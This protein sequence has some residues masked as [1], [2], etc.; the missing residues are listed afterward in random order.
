MPITRID[1]AQP[2][3]LDQAQPIPGGGY[4]IPGYATRVGVLNYRQPNG[5]IRR[6][7]RPPEEAFAP[8]TLASYQGAPLTLTH[9]PS[10]LIRSPAEREKFSVGIVEGQGRQDGEFV[11]VDTLAWAPRALTAIEARTHDRLSVGISIERLD[12]T[13]GVWNGQP[14]DAIQRGITINH[15]AMVSNERAKGSAFR[16]DSGEDFAIAEAEEGSGDMKIRIDGKEVEFGGPEHIAHLEKERSDAAAEATRLKSENA[17][18]Q[19]RFDAQAEELTKAK[20]AA[21]PEVI[22]AAAKARA[23]LMTKASKLGFRGDGSDREIMIGAIKCR[24]DG[25]TGAKDGKPLSDEYIQARFDAAIE[26]LDS[27]DEDEGGAPSRRSLA[28]RV[29]VRA[30]ADGAEREDEGEDEGREDEDDGMS[31]SQRYR[32][33][34]STA[35]QKPIK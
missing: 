18:L 11:E 12:E 33:R 16:L 25:F 21:K 9:P 6:E 28:D 29:A 27:A 24:S 3:R 32:L 26:L 22:Q 1:E 5:T 7:L 19:A 17:A 20:E 15:L 34:L 13:P 4:R 23:D 10:G 2:S 30:D 31:M 8:R 35:W 14:Y